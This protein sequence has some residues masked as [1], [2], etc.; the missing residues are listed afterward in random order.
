MER[1]ISLLKV[2]V[3]VLVIA[4]VSYFLYSN[5]KLHDSVSK[6]WQE[7]TQYTGS[8]KLQKSP[9]FLFRAENKLRE[10]LASQQDV[11]FELNRNRLM[12]E[13]KVSQ[14]QARMRSLE[15]SLEAN[16]KEYLSLKGEVKEG[17]DDFNL[18]SNLDTLVSSINRQRLEKANLDELNQTN[19][20]N[21]E[22]LVNLENEIG[23]SSVVA[24]S[25]DKE[26]QSELI[27]LKF[28]E[29]TW[30]QLRDK[31]DQIIFSQLMNKSDEYSYDLE[32]NYSITSGNAGHIMV[33]INQKVRGKLGKKGQ[34]VDSLVIYKDFNN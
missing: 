19:K 32:T 23:V 27:T 5:V 20:K 26:V 3:M 33:L 9:Q 7:A 4:T 6:G 24:S 13:G 28:L 11:V 25:S 15:G 31:N 1:L 34:V 17:E 29:D 18:N 30:I 16:V 2:P 21:K 14:G 12:L 22:K 10:K 8:E